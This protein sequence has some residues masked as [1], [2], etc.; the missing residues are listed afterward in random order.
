[1]LPDL[2]LLRRIEVLREQI[3]GHNYLY[4]VLD[5]PT[6]SD[7]EY[8]ALMRELLELEGRYP[9][10]V[11]S[12]SP[13]QRVGAPPA[14][15]FPQLTHRAPML[16]LANVFSASEFQAWYTKMISRASRQDLA[17]TCELKIDGI[18]VSLSY[19]DGQ[20][21]QG[22]T[23]GDGLR[24]E[25]VTNNLRTLDSI[26]L[27]LRGK[28]P[29]VL[30]VRGEV[31]IPRSSFRLLNEMR[32][33][34][35]LPPYANPRNAGAGSVRQLDPQVTATRPLEIFAYGIGYATEEIEVPSTQSGILK[36]LHEL[37]FKTNPHNWR[38]ASTNEVIEYY[39]W[40]LERRQELDYQT[41]GVV[42]KVEDRSCWDALGVVGRE[43]RWAVAYKW[44]A[45]QV[46]T[47]LLEIRINVGRTGSLNPYAVLEPVQ[48]SGVTVRQATLHNGDYIRRKDL[49][50]G[51]WVVVERS[52]E[53]IPQVVRVL[54]QHRQAGTR[55]FV[56][57]TRCPRCDSEVIRSDGEVKVRCPNASCPAQFLER[58][59]HFAQ[60]LEIEGLGDQWSRVLIDNGLVKDLADVYALDEKGLI[61]LERM[62]RALSA[63][64]LDQIGKSKD[65]ALGRLVCALA[66]S[67][68][69]AEVAELLTGRFGSMDRLCAAT[70]EELMEIPGIGPRIAETVTAFF[71]A[72]QN[73]MLIEKLRAAGVNM[74]DDHR[75]TVALL[76]HLPLS[77]VGFCL[78]G[79]LESMSRSQGEARVKALGGATTG[80]ITRKTTYLVIGT[81]PG[82][83]KLAQAQQ[84]GTTLLS[85]DQFLDLIGRE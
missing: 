71:S 20:L 39:H 1:M 37:G 6:V 23:R 44:P 21:V 10:L 13:T 40:W 36:W 48:V 64:L 27:R 69:G 61:A 3:D 8:D 12:Q 51:D 19:Y 52:G 56:M 14:D 34:D 49:R 84:N 47:R 50:L 81:S 32:V 24:G 9:E 75:A 22:A 77:G 59:S 17:M 41:D 72:P 70:K 42:V 18:A 28:L 57:P 83:K 5:A 53:V 45:Q 25:E 43:P 30:E 7:D 11:V 79:V 60:T 68:V 26:P 31:Y 62:G 85:E 38:C 4:H 63:K 15:G 35:G 80:S 54:D 82:S 65:C 78:T 58:L 66:I 46:V 29:G 33:A 74:Q 67:H 2:D 16:S 76:D 55:E 73:R